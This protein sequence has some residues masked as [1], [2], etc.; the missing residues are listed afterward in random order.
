MKDCFYKAIVFFCLF[1]AGHSGLG[2]DI[3]KDLVFDQ[4]SKKEGLPDNFINTIFQDS[5]GFLWLATNHGLSRYDGRNFRNYNTLGNNGITDK[6]ISCITEDRKGNIWF[7][8]ESGL[9][10]LDP[11]TDKIT[12]YHEGVGPGTI[13][14]SWCNYLYTDREKNIWL[15]AEKGVAMYHEAIDSFQNFSIKVYDKDKRINKFI[16]EIVED[17][18]GKL[19]MATSYGVKVFDKKTKT[20]ISYFKEGINNREENVFYSIFID[21]RGIIWASAFNQG[22]FKFNTTT[23]VF[24]KVAVNAMNGENFVI[25]GISE[26]EV[27]DKHYLLLAT[28]SGLISVRFDNSDPV[29]FYSLPGHYLTKTI[30]DRQNNLWVGAW[31]GLFKLNLNSLAFKWIPLSPVPAD[32]KTIYHIIPDIQNAGVNYF[33]TTLAGWYA[34]NSLSRSITAHPLPADKNELLLF[35]NHYVPTDK[36]YWFTSVHGF[37]YYDLYNNKLI[38]L[39][40]IT[41][42]AS[43]EKATGYI[44]N[45]TDNTYWITLKRSGIL[46]HNELTKKDTVL[47]GDKN[48]PDNTYGNIIWDMQQSNDGNIWFTSDYKL[49][50][51]NPVTFSYKTF[52]SPPTGEKL[53]KVKTSPLGILFTKT[54][55]ILVYSHLRIYEFKNEQLIPVY[56][57]KGVSNFSIG[58][59]T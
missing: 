3:G 50:I 25:S 52:I 8:T 23:H 6:V 41:F 53:D 16:K 14:Y 11:F 17:N 31:E 57:A 7:G 47:F 51:V 56:P 59:I 2:Q 42:R 4:L 21:H 32:K 35:I 46:V 18:D 55:K 36:G 33:L 9:N 19:W 58:R 45:A 13:P 28:N 20:Y 26:M 22:L 10:R 24:E 44:L 38:D 39:S 29:S 48:K 40:E 30:T 34:Y 5:R 15:A 27:Q 37:G 43:G 12:Q 49:Y 54:G 1:L